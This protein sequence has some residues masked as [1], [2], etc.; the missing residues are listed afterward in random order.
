MTDQVNLEH[1]VWGAPEPAPRRWG[2]RETA[3]AVGIAVVV[4][5][6]GGAAI[7]AASAPS[8]PHLTGPAHGA[9]GP[10]PGPGCAPGG[11]VPDLPR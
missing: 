11:S 3:M 7:Y 10:P 9:F 1:G 5:A 8:A 4:A 2:A 6:F